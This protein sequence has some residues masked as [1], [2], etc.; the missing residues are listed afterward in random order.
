MTRA[1][2]LARGLGTRMRATD[3]GAVLTAAQARAADAGF[4][5]MMPVH[6]RPFL[7]YVL[8]AVADA[9]IERA[10]LI[11]APDHAA[12][13]N[14][15]EH[16]APARVHVEYVV[17]PE[18]LGT[19]NA[20]L[21]AESWCGADPFIVLNSD[22]LYPSAVLT[23]LADL[24]EPGLAVF[25][26]DALVRDSNIPPERIRAFALVEIDAEGYLARIIEK[27]PS[28]VE[29][30]L[31]S[32]NCWRFDA[33]IFDACRDVPRSA[34]GEFELPE[35]VALAVARGARIRGIAASGAVLDMST[36]ADAADVERRLS[37]VVPN[38]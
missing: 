13:R 23:A 30:A 22:N 24:N 6:G 12:I 3:P 32:M 2:V 36:R 5:A 35:A 9:G 14:H 11:V 20:M 8:S 26:R 37:D 21:S 17:Q 18:A 1:L 38:P 19:A 34:R 31:V 33:R 27:P 28:D 15:Y 7:D 16:H 29:A 10:A 4:K 25:A